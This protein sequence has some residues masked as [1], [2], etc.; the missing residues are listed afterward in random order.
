M[1]AIV[2]LDTHVDRLIT[3]QAACY[4]NPLLTKDQIILE[5]YAKAI[6]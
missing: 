6:W 5:N 3:A 1:E 4:G 2:H